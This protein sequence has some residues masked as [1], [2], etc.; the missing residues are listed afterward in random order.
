MHWVCA[1]AQVVCVREAPVTWLGLQHQQD[2]S[3]LHIQSGADGILNPF[4]ASI[5]DCLV[6]LPVLVSP[7]WQLKTC[8]HTRLLWVADACKASQLMRPHLW[9]GHLVRQSN[10]SKGR[11]DLQ[12]A[13]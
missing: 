11:S 6:S 3:L 10:P 4:Q 7:H 5:K 12:Q 13:S 8:L 1:D 2:V 9:P